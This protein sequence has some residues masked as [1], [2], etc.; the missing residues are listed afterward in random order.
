MK[1][2][3][4]VITYQATTDKGEELRY[5]LRSLKNITNW[6]GEVFVVGD[7]EDWFTDKITYVPMKRSAGLAH[8]DVYIKMRKMITTKT[9]AD[10]F[11]FMN[12]DMIIMEKMP[13]K[14]LN[15]GEIKRYAGNNGWLKIKQ[16]TR[17][18]LHNHGYDTPLDYDLHTP[19]IFN[20]KKLTEALDIVEA[21]H[22][23]FQIHVRSI[24]GNIHNIGGDYYEDGKIRDGV[25]PDKPIISTSAMID[26][27]KVKLPEPSE[28]E[29][30]RTEL[31]IRGDYTVDIVIPV[32]NGAKYIKACLDSL[33]KHDKIKQVI[34]CD[35]KSTDDTLKI[36]K[37]YTGRKIKILTNKTNRGVGYS[38]NK[39]LEAVTADYVLRVDSDDTLRPEMSKVLD[40]VIG[41]DIYYYNM[42]DTD[43]SVR[44]C[45]PRNKR[46]LVANFHI[47]KMSLVGDTRTITT[48]WGEDAYFLHELLKKNPTEVFTNV[49]AYGYNYPRADSL[50]GLRKGR[51]KYLLA[52]MTNATNGCIADPT[53]YDTIDSWT[54][55]FGKPEAMEIFLDSNPNP[56][57]ADEYARNIK[58]AYNIEPIRTE[59]LSDGYRRALDMNY[60]FI[61]YLEHDWRIQGVTH[62]LG[63][64]LGWMKTD[65][66][67]F[68]LFNQ[69]KNIDMPELEKWQSYLKPHNSYY[70]L[71][72]RIS[73]NPHIIWREM[74]RSKAMHLVDW[75][76][77]G[78][79]MIEQVLEKKFEVAVYGEY[80]KEP[81]IVHTDGRNGGAK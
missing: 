76:V 24:Y 23:D 42:V 33:P 78:A 38:F 55:T 69:H 61:Y 73:N 30:Y 79:G 27:L 48:N 17:H 57:L 81:T 80:G 22:P 8:R 21:E 34:V 71:T 65:N 36:L 56:Q 11:I 7:S 40:A 64:I 70:S 3:P 44:R 20:K 2:M 75:T 62:S 63:D 51:K 35:D 29:Q 49:N 46:Q 50:T 59:S 39:L 41:H 16:R 1:K 58:R 26:I 13:I 53:I 10:D 52:V 67:W 6:N 18:W 5:T 9:I 37:S 19:M 4:I 28:F 15:Q 72:D 60:E 47:Y 14:H 32:Y 77:R 31:T 66:Q 43:G 25:V 54:A 68:M 12:D 74:Y 45:E